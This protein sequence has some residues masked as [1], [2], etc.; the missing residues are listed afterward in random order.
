MRYFFGIEGKEQDS[1]DN[2]DDD[3][4]DDDECENI[5]PDESE[6]GIRVN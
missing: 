6:R 2:E 1:F 5:R 3:D 4:E